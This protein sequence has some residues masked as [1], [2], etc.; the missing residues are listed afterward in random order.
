MTQG[1]Q[2]KP[3]NREPMSETGSRDLPPNRYDFNRSVVN[4]LSCLGVDALDADV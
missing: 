4:L 1:T 3:D 2:D